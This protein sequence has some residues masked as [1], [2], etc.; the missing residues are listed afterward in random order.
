MQTAAG[1]A[2]QPLTVIIVQRFYRYRLTRAHYMH[3]SCKHP[4]TRRETNK[5]SRTAFTFYTQKMR[6]WIHL[7]NPS[8][9]EERDPS[10]H[11]VTK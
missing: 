11:C 3:V 10:I 9:G 2:S 1:G 8:G 5:N 6:I 7:I 4:C